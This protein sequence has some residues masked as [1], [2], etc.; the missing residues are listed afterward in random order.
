MMKTHV[1]A[2]AKA[3]TKKN[4]VLMLKDLFDK[5][6]TDIVQLIIVPDHAIK[7]LAIPEFGVR[8]NA[9]LQVQ[10]VTTWFNITVTPLRANLSAVN[11]LK[12][13]HIGS[14]D[15]AVTSSLLS[16]I[17]KRAGKDAHVQVHFHLDKDI[18]ESVYGDVDNAQRD[19]MVACGAEVRPVD[20]RIAK[21]IIA[22]LPQSL[23]YGVP[24]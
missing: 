23:T 5:R 4:I 19:V 24:T 7:S 22:N 6:Y 2:K 8:F 17:K 15:L 18:P 12:N 21:N 3:N 1:E 13:E 10:N 16:T 14:W 20:A 11:V 9:P